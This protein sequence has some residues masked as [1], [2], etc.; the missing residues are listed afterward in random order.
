MRDGGAEPNMF[1][2]ERLEFTRQLNWQRGVD[3][4]DAEPIVFHDTVTGKPLFV[5]P[6]GRNMD[7]FL[8]ESLRHGWPSFRQA[9]VVWEN[10]RVLE[11]LEVVSADGTHLGHDIPDSSGPRYC[12]NL[13][14]IS[15]LPTA[16]DSAASGGGDGA[17]T[18]A[19]DDEV[20]RVA[21]AWPLL[22]EL[23][24]IKWRGKMRYASGDDGM[25]PAPFVLSG[26]TCVELGVQ[27]SS[28]PGVTCS[29]V[30]SVVL[31]NGV[32]RTVRMVGTLGGEAGDVARL[33]RPGGGGGGEGGGPVS[34]LLAEHSAA[35]TLLV[36]ELNASTGDAIVT[37]SLVLLRDSDGA[38]AELLQTAHE[39]SQGSGGAGG[40]VGGVQMWRMVPMASAASESEGEEPHDEEAFM[41]SGS[42]L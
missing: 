23:S 34:V 36:R 30:S 22:H 32:E 27:P 10:V 33:E 19:E 29:L 42:E 15:G 13:A 41:Y 28:S 4:S 21:A 24:G 26:T 16:T 38:P 35:D 17:S 20:A 2:T 14:S 9:E 39:L 8:S 7:E 12:I 11:D 3:T 31:P 5:A 6:R 40:G 18:A 37:S 1:F 25:R